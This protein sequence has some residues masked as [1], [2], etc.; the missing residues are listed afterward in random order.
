M[1]LF[2]NRIEMIKSLVPTGGVYAEVGVFE[3]TLSKILQEELS[4]ATFYMIDLFEGICC[5][6]DQDGNNVVHRDLTHEYTKL[7][8][9]ATQQPSVRII[10][11]KSYEFLATLP[12]NSLDMIYV[13]GDHSYEG[14]KK[15]LTVA[16]SKVKSGG[17]IM[18][19]DYEMN[20]MK[21]R[22]HYDFGVRQAADEFC[23]TYNQTITAKGLDGC[24]SFGIHLSK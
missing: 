2:D 20:K 14:C 18:G 16:Y 15:D 7:R 6:G 22:N 13:D 1:H 19:H 5:S 3:G 4:P 23:K 9:Y 10:K 21:A 11:G 24:V 12:D 8:M 17:W